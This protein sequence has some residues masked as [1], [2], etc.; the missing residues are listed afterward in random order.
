MFNLKKTPNLLV[1]SRSPLI[2]TLV[3]RNP[4]YPDRLLKKSFVFKLPVIGSEY[5]L[6]EVQIRRGRNVLQAGTSCKYYKS[7]CKLSMQLILKEN[8]VIRPFCITGLSAAPVNPDKWRQ[9]TDFPNK[10][11]KTSVQVVIYM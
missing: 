10:L 2:R 1:Y 4:N 5:R 8:L 11:N 3:I 7:K 6:M 9:L